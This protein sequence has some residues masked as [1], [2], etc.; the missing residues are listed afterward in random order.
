MDVRPASAERQQA[1]ETLADNGW[2]SVTISKNFMQAVPTQYYEM[3]KWCED[4][5]GPGRMEPGT[6]IDSE[7]VWYSYGWYGFQRFH[8]RYSKDATIFTL[9]WS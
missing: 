2:T 4:N 3:S 5:I 8:F 7:D 1:E 6:I 9:R